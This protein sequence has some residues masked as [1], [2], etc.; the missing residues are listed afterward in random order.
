MGAL[1]GAVQVQSLCPSSC[2]VDHNQ[3][4]DQDGACKAGVCTEGTS[5]RA[6]GEKQQRGSGS[7][8]GEEGKGS[9]WWGR[10]AGGRTL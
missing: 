8:L 2:G 3:R 7:A 5:S 6:H 4:R 9:S 1:P 10:Q